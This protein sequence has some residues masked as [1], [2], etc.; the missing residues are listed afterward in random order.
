MGGARTEKKKK[1]LD[2]ICCTPGFRQGLGWSVGSNCQN[3]AFNLGN[4]NSTAGKLAEKS[5][6]KISITD[7][8]LSFFFSNGDP[9]K[10]ILGRT[11][12][13]EHFLA[14]FVMSFFFILKKKCG[15]VCSLSGGTRTAFACSPQSSNWTAYGTNNTQVKRQPEG[16]DHR[17]DSF[18][19]DF[20]CVRPIFSDLLGDFVKK[21]KIRHIGPPRLI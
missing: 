7:I 6:R 17:S 8:G 20:A 18:F 4:R 13:F 14:F 12:D 10:I 1:R 19:F 15:F 21:C 3:E 2:Q 16:H 9:R 5:M 11:G